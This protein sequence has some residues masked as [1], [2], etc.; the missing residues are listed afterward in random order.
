MKDVAFAKSIED[1]N[2]AYSTVNSYEENIFKEFEL[3][4]ERFQGGVKQS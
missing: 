2:K 4:L 1:I 3:I